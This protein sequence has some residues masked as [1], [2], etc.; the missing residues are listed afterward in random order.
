MLHK[1]KKSSK[2]KHQKSSEERGKGMEDNL[3]TLKE[4]SLKEGDDPL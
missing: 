1:S 4:V 3:I 2:I